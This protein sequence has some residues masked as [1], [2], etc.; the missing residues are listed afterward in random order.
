MIQQHAESDF[1]QKFAL[2]QQLQCQSIVRCLHVF[3]SSPDVHFA[4]ELMNMSLVQVAATLRFP[5]EQEVLAIV[6][7]VCRLT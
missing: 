1:N 6:S 4:F 2:L 7:Q 3:Y 5:R